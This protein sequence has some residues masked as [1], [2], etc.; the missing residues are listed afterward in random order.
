MNYQRARR[1]LASAGIAYIGAFSPDAVALAQAVEARSPDALFEFIQKHN[2]STYVD[3]AVRLAN[4]MIIPAQDVALEQFKL[5][6]KGGVKSCSGKSS[7]GGS[8]C[9]NPDSGDKNATNGY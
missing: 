9:A 6:D 8:D 4:A 1:I 7:F 3:D 5:I 2:E